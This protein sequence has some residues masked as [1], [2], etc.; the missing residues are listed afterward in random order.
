MGGF[1]SL[2]AHQFIANMFQLL[3]V[4]IPNS[5]LMLTSTIMYAGIDAKSQRNFSRK[6]F[7]NRISFSRLL[8]CSRNL[9]CRVEFFNVTDG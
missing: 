1:V 5:D 6:I 3:D 4:F 7:R 9:F 2:R 8:L